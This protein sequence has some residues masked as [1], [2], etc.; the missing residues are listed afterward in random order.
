MR[1]DKPTFEQPMIVT[2][3]RDELMVETASTGTTVYR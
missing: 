1:S 3:G 2:Y